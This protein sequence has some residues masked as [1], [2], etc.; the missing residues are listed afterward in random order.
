MGSSAH[1]RN[2]KRE[3][4]GSFFEADH[5][6]GETDMVRLVVALERDLVRLKHILRW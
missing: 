4:D 3:R 2:V 5:L 6:A 1:L